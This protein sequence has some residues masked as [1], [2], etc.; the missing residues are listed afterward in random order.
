MTRK[1][2]TLILALLVGNAFGWAHYWETPPLEAKSN[3]V[4]TSLL[5]PPWRYQLLLNQHVKHLAY[6]Q[7]P[8]NLMPSRVLGEVLSPAIDQCLEENTPCVA[9]VFGRVPS[10]ADE[11]SYHPSSIL[12]VILATDTWRGQKRF[13]VMI[14][15][16]GKVLESHGAFVPTSYRRMEL[17]FENVPSPNLSLVFAQ[18]K[19]KHPLV[20][21]KKIA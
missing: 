16:E 2:L 9:Y 4:S 11:N 5:L 19:K 20:F 7:F 15:F 21:D 17:Q 14:L 12:K 10:V 13:L 3:R 1:S 8:K 18:L 6:E